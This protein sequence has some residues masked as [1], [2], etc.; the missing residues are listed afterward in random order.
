MS[1]TPNTLVRCENK[2]RRVNLKSKRKRNL[3]KKAIELSK[4]LSV[5][6]LMVFMDHDTGKLSSYSSGDRRVGKYTIEKALKDFEEHRAATR[7]IK[8]FDDDDYASLKSTAC[9]QEQEEVE[10]SLTLVQKRPASES[11]QKIEASLLESQSQ[12]RKSLKRAQDLCNEIFDEKPSE[13]LKIPCLSSL[14]RASTQKEENIVLSPRVFIRNSED[15]KT[16]PVVQ[17]P[18][19]SLDH[20][21]QRVDWTLNEPA[22]ALPE[23]FK[24][25]TE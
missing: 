5:D 10:R 17:L 19:L 11:V 18:T 16:E 4:M 24:N 2:A 12:I 22:P 13:P 25:K 1:S 7:F 8:M 3:I 6:M 23:F 14:T 9:E 20:S 21:I 15:D